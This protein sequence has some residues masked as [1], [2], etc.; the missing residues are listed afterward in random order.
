MDELLVRR[1]VCR[2]QLPKWFS[3]VL[4]LVFYSSAQAGNKYF[5]LKTS[6][7]LVDFKAEINEQSILGAFILY[8][9]VK[10]QADYLL[11][12][13]DDV[14]FFLIHCFQETALLNVN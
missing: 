9:Y 6:V 2:Q 14:A 7:S 13:S 3:F 8:I 4:L 1:I 12:R 11:L 5:F 10:T